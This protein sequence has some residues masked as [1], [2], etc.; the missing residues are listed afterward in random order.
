MNLRQALEKCLYSDKA[1]AM[2]DS[3]ILAPKIEAALRAAYLK[4]VED[5]TQG[6]PFYRDDCSENG[7]TAGIEAM[8]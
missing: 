5:Q 2:V 4:G 7:V 3:A 8:Q 1:T 6:V